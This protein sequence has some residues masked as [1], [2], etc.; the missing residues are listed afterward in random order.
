MH[1]VAWL[2]ARDDHQ[3]LRAAAQL[4]RDVMSRSMSTTFQLNPNMDAQARGR[5][6]HSV[7]RLEHPIKAEDT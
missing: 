5:E 2:T 6:K 1:V 3:L 7:L 4:P